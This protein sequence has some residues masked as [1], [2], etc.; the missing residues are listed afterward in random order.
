MDKKNAVV[1]RKDYGGI[2]FHFDEMMDK[3]GINRNQLATRAAI[4]F[5]VAD[6]FYNGK[7]ERLDVD[8]LAR[9]CYVLD[10]GVADV[11]R[12]SK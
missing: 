4:R 6:R 1:V 12:Y 10:C 2:T 7:L 11:M 5:E 8:V 3:R 9:V